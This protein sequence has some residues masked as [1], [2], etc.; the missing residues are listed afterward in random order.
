MS[1]EFFKCFLLPASAAAHLLR[2]LPQTTMSTG[3]GA[4]SA[5]VD[6]SSVKS[7]DVVASNALPL[8]VPRTPWRLLFWHEIPLWQQDNEYILSGHRSIAHA[9]FGLSNQL[10]FSTD[11]PPSQHGLPSQASPTLTTRRSTPTHTRLA[12]SYSPCF[13]Y[14]FI[15]MSSRISQM[16]N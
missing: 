8:G 2:L 1:N 6:S 14:I 15:N 5:S 16:L 4:P 11:L 13:L 3:G 10:I 9:S 7:Q 12:R